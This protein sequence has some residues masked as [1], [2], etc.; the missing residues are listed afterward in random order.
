MKTGENVFETGLYASDCCLQEILFEAGDSFSRC[1]RCAN[2]SV[3]ETVE[4]AA[5][6]KLQVLKKSSGIGIRWPRRF[7]TIGMELRR[8]L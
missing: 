4:I 5:L 2:L 1:P 8:S 3:W 6:E 7:N